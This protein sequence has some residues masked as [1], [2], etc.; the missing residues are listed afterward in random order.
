[1]CHKEA[2]VVAEGYTNTYV[3]AEGCWETKNVIQAYT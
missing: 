3:V 1:V 2:K